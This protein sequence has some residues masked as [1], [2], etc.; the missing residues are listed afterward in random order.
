M[1]HVVTCE[2]ACFVDLEALE[3]AC[4]DVGCELRRDQA[5][6]KWYGRYFDD[7]H[8]S[9]AAYRKGLDPKDYGR[10]ARHVI[11]VKDDSAA[12]EVGLVDHPSGQGF[13]P[14][15]D[16]YGS[17]GNRISSRVGRSIEKLR[18]AYAERSIRRRAQQQGY[19]VQKKVLPNGHVQLIAEPR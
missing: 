6:W 2:D 8:G 18:T 1:S 13:M 9:D 17:D 5:S 3:Q 15:Y 16:F 7:Y 19:S 14:V 10:K 12:Y 4:N 11:S